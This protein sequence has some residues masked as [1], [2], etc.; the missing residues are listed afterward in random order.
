VVGLVESG[1]GVASDISGG[2]ELALTQQSVFHGK[3]PSN[4]SVLIFAE[5]VSAF[6][7]SVK[8]TSAP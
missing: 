3:S 5:P 8:L 1:K 2:G 4:F 7:A 6:R